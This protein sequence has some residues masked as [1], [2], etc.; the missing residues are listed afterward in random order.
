M[1]YNLTTIPYLYV[2][3]NL[4]QNPVTTIEPNHQTQWRPNLLDVYRQIMLTSHPWKE[5]ESY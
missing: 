4:F 1:L 5:D 3:V 2:F